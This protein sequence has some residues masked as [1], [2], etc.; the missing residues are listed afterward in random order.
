MI[1]VLLKGLLIVILS[2][3]PF[4]IAEIRAENVRIHARME[5]LRAA[6]EYRQ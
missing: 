6:A 4:F 1:D 5:A 2:M 3:L